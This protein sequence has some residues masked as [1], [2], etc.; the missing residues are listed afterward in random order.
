MALSVKIILGQ[1]SREIG[2]GEIGGR[3]SFAI[4]GCRGLSAASSCSEAGEGCP[5]VGPAKGADSIRS[6]SLAAGEIIVGKRSE[7]AS[8]EYRQQRA[9]FETG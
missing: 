7:A 4:E 3:R 5:E 1:S 8:L 9:E 6:R 2:V